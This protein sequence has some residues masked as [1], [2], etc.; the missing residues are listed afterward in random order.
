M[1]KLFFAFTVLCAI[2]VHAADTPAQK[3]K[4]EQK[5]MQ[6]DENKRVRKYVRDLCNVKTTVDA[7]VKQA[8]NPKT[9]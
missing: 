1:K 6:S 5:S 7:I 4:A 8:K 2:S 9:K 3:E